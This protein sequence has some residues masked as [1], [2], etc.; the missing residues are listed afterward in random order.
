MSHHSI[1]SAID[2][3]R[4]F[5]NHWKPGYGSASKEDLRIIQSLINHYK[6][7]TFLEI[8][9]ASGLSA[10]FIALFMNP[11]GEGSLITIDHDNTF[12]GDK[13]K[14]N[15]FLIGEIYSHES[16]QVHKK[17]FT[18]SIDLED[19]GFSYDMA[20]IDANHQHPWPTIDLLMTYPHLSANKIA[21]F[22]DL[23]LFKKQED[24]RGIGPRILYD[25]FSYINKHRPSP[26]A[27]IYYLDL[28]SIGAGHFL[29]AA[30]TSLFYPW[31][32]K[33]SIS[34]RIIDRVARRLQSCYGNY[35]SNTFKICS[36]RYN[37][38]TK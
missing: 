29:E 1:L 19:T 9:M 34:E 15:G 30:A 21:I 4:I 18:T 16:V 12:F 14:E 7:K 8:G 37:A 5:N 11:H 23:D 33:Q 24:A 35:I 6:P 27:D 10:G 38:L 25:Q 26:S 36:A 3:E 17:P 22:D 13:N 28:S 20:F 2:I 32:V 31:T